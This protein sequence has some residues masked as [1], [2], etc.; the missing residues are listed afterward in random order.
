MNEVLLENSS[1]VTTDNYSKL[2]FYYY[3][4]IPFT[5]ESYITL[6]VSLFITPRYY[7]NIYLSPL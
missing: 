6:S 7:M 3:S 5:I 4:I 2:L 1:I